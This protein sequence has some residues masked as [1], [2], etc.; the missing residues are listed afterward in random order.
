MATD[1]SDKPVPSGMYQQWGPGGIARAEAILRRTDYLSADELADV[2]EHNEG[3]PLPKCL[4]DY[5]VRF[6]RGEVKKKRGPKPKS[7]DHDAL[8]F[9][10]AVL[11]YGKALRV[12]S[13]L[14]RRRKL[15]AKKRG[16]TLPRALEPPH[17]LAL[18]HVQDRV[19][20]YRDMELESLHNLLSRRRRQSKKRPDKRTNKRKG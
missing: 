20:Y 15:R 8:Y 11:L 5:L 19:G 14:H 2:L 16:E 7:P 4:Q 6:L 13:K 10:Y 12:Y 9:S 18:K 17:R 1:P 3:R